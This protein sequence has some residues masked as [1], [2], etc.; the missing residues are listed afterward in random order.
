MNEMEDNEDIAKELF[1]E[2]AEEQEE[3]GQPAKPLNQPRK[4]RMQSTIY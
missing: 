2:E 3:E 4:P 1:G